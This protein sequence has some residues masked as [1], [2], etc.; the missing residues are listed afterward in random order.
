MSMKPIHV[1]VAV[2]TNAVGEIFIARRPNHV[3]QGGLWEFPGGKIEPGES[4]AQALN[5]ELREELGV[6]AKRACPLI[7]IAHS[8]PDKHVVLDVWCVAE[9][10]GEPHGR[11]GQPVRW[12]APDHLNRIEFPKANTPIV[13]AVQLPAL[14]LVT[15]EPLNG[16]DDF[17]ARLESA[18]RAGIRLVQLRAKTVTNESDFVVLAQRA[19]ALCRTHHARLLLNSTPEVAARV[20][21]DGVHL[22]AR[23]L[24]NLEQRPPAKSMWVSASCHSVAELRH[25]HAIGVDFA[26]LA[27]VLDTRTHPG[28]AVLGWDGFE[29]LARTA[30][31]PVYA[32]GGMT[33]TQG[34]EAQRRGG[35]GIAV[36]GAIW[37]AADCARAV[38]EITRGLESG[39]VAL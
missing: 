3:H 39:W 15:G 16:A 24:M 35:Q 22:T 18:L 10:D 23:H 5:R 8:Y 33:A 11:E 38:A 37:D 12:V 21:A 36:L 19:L 7:Q 28:A 25:A 2:I 13:T 20:G 30:S 1:A 4:V 9:L 26:L 6:S 14:L 17:L 31:L 34:A 32:L 29:A 27:P